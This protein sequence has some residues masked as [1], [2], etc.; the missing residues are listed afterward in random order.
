MNV[1]MLIANENTE[2]AQ[3]TG[4]SMLTLHG[5]KADGEDIILEL[6]VRKIQSV[7][8]ARPAAPS[9]LLICFRPSISVTISN[10]KSNKILVNKNT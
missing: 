1:I 6:I 9:V 4:C 2:A 10:R 3:V 5:S 7:P 8:Q